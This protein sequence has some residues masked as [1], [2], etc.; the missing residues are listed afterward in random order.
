MRESLSE[1]APRAMAVLDPIKVTLVNWPE[2]KIDEIELENHPDHPE[3]G[4]RTLRFGRTLFIE[5]DDFMLDPPKKFFRL[6][7][8]REVRLKGAYIIRC[9][10]A[11][12]GQGG[13]VAELL[14]TVDL[15]SKSG[16]QGA[17]RKVKGTLHWLSSPDA[18]PIEARLYEPILV[19][20]GA[21]AEEVEIDGE[22]QGDQ[23]PPA[24]DFIRRLNPDSIKVMPN[25]L[26]EPAIF[27]APVG[28]KFQFLRLGYFCKDPDST[29]EK[30]VYN[31]A[32]G[33]KDS[34]AKVKN[35]G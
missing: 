31:R 16:G 14:C 11:V 10:S 27:D 20:E 23:A 8:G 34:W 28:G 33:L 18:R 5:R 17:G 6:S 2:D 4:S 19:D 1:I 3:M 15:D 24:R 12:P 29:P 35:E 32:V 21:V 25:A 22:V 7:P 9:E 13:E 30:A 26:A